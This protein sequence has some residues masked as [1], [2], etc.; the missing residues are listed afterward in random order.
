M[1]ESTRRGKQNATPW[2]NRRFL[3]CRPTHFAVT[4]R[5]NPWMDPTAPYDNALAVSQWEN[6]RRTFLDLGHTVEEIDPLPG[7]PDMVFAANGATV[8]DGTV[9]SA[10]FRY[11]ERAAE[12][13]A[14][15]D[16]F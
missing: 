3:M 13:P 8:I 4:Y 12:A 5:I 10:Q 9:Y 7:L 1:T 6:L 2:S 15:L 14:Y 11:L 16:W